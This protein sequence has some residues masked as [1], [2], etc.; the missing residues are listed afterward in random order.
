MSRAPLA[1]VGLKKERFMVGPRILGSTTSSK[2]IWPKWQNQKWISPLNRLILD[3][4][5][6][7][8]VTLRKIHD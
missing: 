7:Y 4:M 2:K 3:S 8:T 5:G 1:T 6:P